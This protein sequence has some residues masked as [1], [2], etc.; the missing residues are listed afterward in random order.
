MGAVTQARSTRFQAKN[1]L[2]AKKLSLFGRVLRLLENDRALSKKGLCT[3]QG[4]VN[5]AVVGEA[6]VGKDQ[7]LRAMA[8]TL[9]PMLLIDLLEQRDLHMV[10]KSGDE[11]RK[12]IFDVTGG[13]APAGTDIALLVMDATKGVN[14][15]AK[16]HIAAAKQNGACYIIPVFNNADEQSNE[17]EIEGMVEAIRE[18]LANA[19]YDGWNLPVFF[20]D[21]QEALNEEDQWQTKLVELL[22]A[23]NGWAE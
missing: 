20:T 17:G 13:N 6:G 5:V 8:I 18:E 12:Y 1:N 10:F 3:V 14:Q 7:L 4:D 2:V 22:E 15:A 11:K 23:L 9:N 21:S 16:D 19:E